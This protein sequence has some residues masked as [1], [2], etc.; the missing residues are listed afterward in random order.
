MKKAVTY[1]LIS[2]MLLGISDLFAQQ[3]QYWCGTDKHH[4]ELMKSNPEYRKSRESSEQ[5]WRRFVQENPVFSKTTGAPVF[6]I[7]V[8]FHVIHNYGPENISK[9][10]ILTE[11][12]YLNKSFQNMWADS[13]N[14]NPPFKP[15][16]ADCQIEFKLAQI[17]PWGNCTDGITR[18]VSDYTYG[19]DNL[20]KGLIKWPSNKYMNV[21]VVA[22]IANAGVAAYA[23][24]PAN[25][26]PNDGIVT[27][28]SFVGAQSSNYNER[29]LTHEVGHWLN[30][31][32]TWGST[33]DPGLPQ[34]CSNDDFVAD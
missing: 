12:E 3:T 23:T 13:V 4:V 24:Y 6:T 26:N 31:P 25:N 33:N 11:M 27:R 17:D 19:Q 10:R 2:L 22:D 7:P 1:T 21:W 5:Q 30:L 32:H 8:V 9:D 16:L 29:V 34:N 18:T 15:S 20:V 28:Y 14:I